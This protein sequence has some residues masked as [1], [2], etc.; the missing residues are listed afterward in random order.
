M[1][2]LLHAVVKMIFF[3][4]PATKFRLTEDMFILV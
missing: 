2:F 1:K 3:V 4:Q